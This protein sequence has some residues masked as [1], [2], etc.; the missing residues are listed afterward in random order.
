MLI[1]SVL[2]V[3]QSAR[4]DQ[5]KAVFIL[6]SPVHGTTKMILQDLIRNNSFEYCVLITSAHAR[7]HMF[8]K[9]GGHRE[10]IEGM[11][12]FHS[13]EEEMLEWMGNMVCHIL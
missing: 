9:Y 5:K 11:S 4:P 13:V 8:A 7:V 10:G 12:L 2:T 3:F 6:C 1:T